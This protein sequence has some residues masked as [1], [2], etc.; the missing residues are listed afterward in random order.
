MFQGF[1][2]TVSNSRYTAH[3]LNVI[4][5]ATV[6]QIDFPLFPLISLAVNLIPA[7]CGAP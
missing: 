7:Y 1:L 3:H 6:Q 4:P 2:N 5:S